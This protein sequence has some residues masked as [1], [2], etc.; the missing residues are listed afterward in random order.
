MTGRDATVQSGDSPL[1]SI[2]LPTFNGERY[3]REALDSCLKQTYRHWELV[4]VDD[5][6]TDATSA[7]LSEYMQGDDRIH[8][9]RHA[10]NRGLPT[11]LNTGFAHSVGSLLTWTSDD[12]RFYP[13]FLEHMVRLLQES[14]E[15]DFV[16]TDVELIDEEGHV[17]RCETAM[18]PEQLITGFHGLGL[19]GFLY[20]R[21]V[22]ERVGDY[23]EDL[24]LA[25]DYDY[26]VRVFSH[27][28]HMRHLNE[29]LYQ[30]RRHARSLTDTHAGKPFLA[31]ER[32][33][34]RNLPDMPHLSRA[35]R[36]RAYLFLAT[37]ATWR[38]DSRS[39]L[40]YTL[41][42]VP[43]AP[44]PA[45]AKVADFLRKRLRHQSGKGGVSASAGISQR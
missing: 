29:T 45:V 36:G 34:L 5:A 26:W 8:C 14:P 39:A 30:Y 31:A 38:G 40:G 24:I 44:A 17:V 43:L 41:R 20:R 15:V 27:G 25:E 3:L 33:L 16:Y 35:T 11:A 37:L 9:T 19:A 21:R 42:A 18:E 1:I 23:A 28:F 7:I 22:R 32:T 12:N 10:T 4:V 6:S 2:V 13:H